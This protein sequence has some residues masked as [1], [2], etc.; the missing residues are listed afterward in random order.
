MRLGER[1]AQ[2]QRGRR[3]RSTHG[4]LRVVARSHAARAVLLVRGRL[5]QLRQRRAFRLVL[6]AVT[7]RRSSTTIRDWRGPRAGQPHDAHRANLSVHRSA[8]RRG[9]PC[10]S[11]RGV[12]I[13][14]G[15]TRDNDAGRIGSDHRGQDS[16]A[17]DQQKIYAAA[18]R[19][20]ATVEPSESSDDDE[21]RRSWYISQQ[22]TIP[23][24]L[25][26]PNVARPEPHLPRLPPPQ[27]DMDRSRLET[28]LIDTPTKAPRRRAPVV[29]FNPGGI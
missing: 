21:Q 26:P 29:H 15:V 11:P 19:T 22:W 7:L 10:D 17:T 20:D 13:E 24:E 16:L 23:K 1:H 5:Q 12:R 3:P 2:L 18:D 28:A 8:G 6:V 4:A 27:A 25:R 9:R 14:T